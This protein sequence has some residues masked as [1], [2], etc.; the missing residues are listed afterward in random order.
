MMVTVLSREIFSHAFSMDVALD[1]CDLVCQTAI[2]RICR[3][4]AVRPRPGTV[5]SMNC[6]RLCRIE[7][8]GRA[9]D[10]RSG[11]RVQHEWPYCFSLL[12]GTCAPRS[13]QVLNNS[14][15]AIVRDR[16]AASVQARDS[17]L[18]GRA[19]RDAR[20]RGAPAGVL[21]PFLEGS[22][23]MRHC[24]PTLRPFHAIGVAGGGKRQSGAPG[25]A[26][27]T[28]ALTS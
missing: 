13:T 19:G 17:N 25:G 12:L 20:A 5:V 27:G 4:S 23:S 7:L 14:T 8:I 11:F 26:C 2:L 9:G 21:L 3:E 24:S 6:R 22:L 15:N 28:G 1:R 16:L 10:R 18:R